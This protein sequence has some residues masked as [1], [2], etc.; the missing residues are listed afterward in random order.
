MAEMG[1]PSKY[2]DEMCQEVIEMGKLGKT[3]VQMACALDID[4]VTLHAWRQEKA[5]FSYAIDVALQHAQAWWEEKG[6]EATFGEI[7]GFSAPAYNYQMKNRF[8]AD[9]FRD[10]WSDRVE[11]D[12]TTGGKPI[13]MIERVIINAPTTDQD[14]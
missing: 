11:Q 8:K 4:R 6:Q 5:N 12:H 13:G 14:A 3:L 7:P 1:R 2:R 10:D 9:R